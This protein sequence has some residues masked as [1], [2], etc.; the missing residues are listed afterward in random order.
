[1]DVK[2]IRVKILRESVRF[3]NLAEVKYLKQVIIICVR[4]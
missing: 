2:K 3:S 4:C 1:M